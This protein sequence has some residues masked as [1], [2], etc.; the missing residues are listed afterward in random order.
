MPARRRQRYRASP[1]AVVRDNAGSTG[2]VS[3]SVSTVVG[4]ERTHAKA[5]SVVTRS[6][7]GCQSDVRLARSG[8][9]GTPAVSEVSPTEKLGIRPA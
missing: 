8:R 4:F 1:F 7:V 5:K 2:F 3:K 6:C 9:F